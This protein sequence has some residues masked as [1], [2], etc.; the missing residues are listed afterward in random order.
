MR[1][2]LLLALL[3][4]LA[5]G[6]QV[7]KCTIDGKTVYS[8]SQCGLHGQTVNATVNSLDTSGMRAQSD[9]ME[10]KFARDA[11]LDAARQKSAERDARKQRDRMSGPCPGMDGAAYMSC[12][13]DRIKKLGQKM[14]PRRHR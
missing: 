4:P 11:A 2:L 9:K 5:V 12:Q 3:L 7:K 8:D 13:S 6:A 10:Q 1:L 14:E